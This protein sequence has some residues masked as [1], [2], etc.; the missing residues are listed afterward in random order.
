MEAEGSHLSYRGQKE[1]VGANGLEM[2]ANMDTPTMQTFL[3]AAMKPQM[4][5]PARLQMDGPRRL[6]LGEWPE[7][8]V[9]LM[10]SNVGDSA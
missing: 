5:R 1:E 8:S 9:P 3:G 4:D 2:E 7:A 6:G 10:D